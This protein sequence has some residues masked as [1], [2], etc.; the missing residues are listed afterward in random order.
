MVVGEI[1]GT[2]QPGTLGIV[3]AMSAK[4]GSSETAETMRA[5]RSRSSAAAL[6][7][8]G[9]RCGH[10]PSTP[11]GQRDPGVAYP[12]LEAAQEALAGQ[13]AAYQEN[14]SAFPH[15]IQPESATHRDR[16]GGGCQPSA[17]AAQSATQRG[18]LGWD[19]TAV[20]LP[21]LPGAMASTNRPGRAQHQPDGYTYATELE[22]RTAL[23]ETLIRHYSHPEEF[24][25]RF[26]SDEVTPE[27]TIAFITEE[28]L[29]TDAADLSPSTVTGY[30]S[31]RR[32]VCHPDHGI[33]DKLATELTHANLFEWRN[34]AMKDAG[35]TKHTRQGAYR[36]LS[37]VLSR[38]VEL[39]NIPMNPA[40]G[41]TARRRRSGN[42]D[43]RPAQR[44]VL[45]TRQE[46]MDLATA[47][48]DKVDRLLLL[49]LDVGGSAF[50]REP[51]ASCL[52]VWTAAP[53]RSSS[54]RSGSVGHAA[55]AGSCDN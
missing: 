50:R 36:F 5:A 9:L 25:L 28:F 3:V 45:P 22:A 6:T 20:A 53:T 30:R 38:E 17:S 26:E 1:P 35:V 43:D 31:N 24:D 27:R 40:L 49:V 42:I 13:L 8:D 39:G 29:R 52:I 2:S 14:P 23:R 11:S 37:S 15:L 55:R 47:I 4:R 33:G 32:V 12:T 51:Q 34:V 18:L 7:P 48:P 41:S 54:T 44:V 21:A 19:G 10:A 16:A 46:E